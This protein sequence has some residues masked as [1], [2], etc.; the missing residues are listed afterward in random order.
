M[1]LI[2]SDKKLRSRR[3]CLTVPAT[4]ERFLRKATT[5]EVDEVILDLEDSVPPAEKTEATRLRLASVIA[6]GEWAAP[7]V[8]VR[9]NAT[10]THHCLLDLVTV[11]PRCNGNLHCVV[12]PKVE[13]PFD[14]MFVERVLGQLETAYGLG[15]EIGIEI[16]IESA[17]GLVHC[18]DIAAASPR[19][20][21]LIFGPG[22]F[23]ASIGT[24]TLD[25]G[26][27]A[28]QADKVW[29]APAILALCQILTAARA[30]GVQ[31]IDGPH[32]GLDD[33][34][35]LL[36]SAR[37][38]AAF[39]FDGKWAIHP[40]QV[41]PLKTAFTPSAAQVQQAE[42]L[43]AEY[44]SVAASGHGAAVVGGGMI[45]EASVRLAANILRRLS[46]G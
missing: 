22:D 25:I 35:G 28:A 3:A 11:V 30:A 8:T 41:E 5:I 2:A 42:H 10:Y 43:L 13:S 31:A 1:N 46:A 17:N 21:S 12:L 7:T 32:G 34:E 29:E 16:L 38:T 18:K 19:V 45:D 6:A 36:T 23:A 15:Y 39:G 9:L 27:R 40:S 33:P 44:R 37:R 20:E 4:N 14:V 26:V 24:P